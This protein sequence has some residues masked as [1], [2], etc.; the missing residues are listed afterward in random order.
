VVDQCGD[1][2]DNRLD[3]LEGLMGCDIHMVIEIKAKIKDKFGLLQ[4]R[5]ITCS[6]PNWKGDKEAM[7]R[8]YPRFAALAGVRGEG[9]DP[10][11]LPEGATDTSRYLSKDGHSH[12]WLPLKQAGRV[13]LESEFDYKKSH[14]KSDLRERYPVEHYFGIPDDEANAYRLIFWFDN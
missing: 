1:R 4:D 6:I 9:P 7:D 10:R 5:W 3:D 8:N 11:G 2:R 12:S 13:F 14:R